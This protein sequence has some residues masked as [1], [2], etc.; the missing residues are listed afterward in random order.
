MASFNFQ[1]CTLQVLPADYR[2]LGKV[3]IKARGRKIEWICPKCNGKNYIKFE[4]L[5]YEFGGGDIWSQVV[6]GATYVKELNKLIK[7]KHD[8][9]SF[10]FKKAELKAKYLVFTGKELQI[11]QAATTRIE[12]KCKKCGTITPFNLEISANSRLFPLF[13][14]PSEK[15][16]VE[17]LEVEVLP[18]DSAEIIER[19]VR[20][21]VVYTL[22][23]NNHYLIINKRSTLNGINLQGRFEENLQKNFLEWIENLKNDME[24]VVLFKE[25]ERKVEEIMGNFKTSEI[26]AYFSDIISFIR[27]IRRLAFR[28]VRR[29]LFL[30]LGWLEEQIESAVMSKDRVT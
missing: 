22:I 17:S 11:K 25:I 10:L 4:D 19:I 16:T 3:R 5:P 6:R 13:S 9:I 8:L 27:K 15:L 7:S 12:G 23:K 26:T 24:K 30:S 18:N 14:V 21:Y 29:K 28:R 2:L 20:G 1:N